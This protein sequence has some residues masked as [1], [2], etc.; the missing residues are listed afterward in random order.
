M[1]IHSCL[2]QHIDIKILILNYLEIDLVTEV[3]YIVHLDVI[4]TENP[5]M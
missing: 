2:F 3:T 5:I 1:Y 4:L